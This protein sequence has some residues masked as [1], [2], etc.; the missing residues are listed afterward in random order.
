MIPKSSSATRQKENIDLFG[1]KLSQDEVDRISA[2]DKGLRFNDPVGA[3][4]FQASL[5][6]DQIFNT[7]TK[8]KK[9]ADLNGFIKGDY[10]NPPQRIFA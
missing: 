6:L 5:R 4:Q 3:L 2:L 9:L 10:L 7:G 8:V 1:F